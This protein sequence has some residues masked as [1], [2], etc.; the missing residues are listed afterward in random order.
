MSGLQHFL[1][2]MGLTPWPD[3]C[4]T[5]LR[6]SVEVNP[7]VKWRCPALLNVSNDVFEARTMR[8]VQRYK[9]AG[10]VLPEMP[11]LRNVTTCTLPGEGNVWCELPIR[12]F[13]EAETLE[14]MKKHPIPNNKPPVDPNCRTCPLIPPS[15]C[16]PITG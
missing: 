4:M 16:Q 6:Y 8:F 13:T 2:V 1:E 14:L 15:V 3:K 11:N 7:H 12:K 9:D 5:Q 10:I